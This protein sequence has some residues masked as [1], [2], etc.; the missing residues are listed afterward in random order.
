MSNFRRNL[1]KTVH[2]PHKTT[3][4]T[5]RQ[6]RTSALNHFPGQIT[7][8][9]FLNTFQR[10]FLSCSRRILPF[11]RSSVCGPLGL[12]NGRGANPEANR[13]EQ[14]RKGAFAGGEGSPAADAALTGRKHVYRYLRR[15]DSR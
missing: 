2:P 14:I 4:R 3:H 9:P 10:H 7:A 1:T 6:Q 5:V 12:V 15:G 13:G 11:L 8:R